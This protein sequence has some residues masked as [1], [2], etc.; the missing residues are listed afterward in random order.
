[1]G[2]RTSGI[3]NKQCFHNIY[4]KLI[5]M[6]CYCC[7]I[8]QD[9][10]STSTCILTT[11]DL[12]NT[13]R[14]ATLIQLKAV[15]ENPLVTLTQQEPRP[16]TFRNAINTTRSPSSTGDVCLA[17]DHS[18]ESSEHDDEETHV[19]DVRTT[20][21]LRIEGDICI[22]LRIVCESCLMLG[23]GG[24]VY[25]DILSEQAERPP[26][27]ARKNRNVSITDREFRSCNLDGGPGVSRKGAVS[28]LTNSH[29]AIFSGSFE[30]LQS[31]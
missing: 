23:E 19:F 28:H 20:C 25:I 29:P 30:R 13:A 1:M 6:T 5:L 16:A 22:A 9:S 21:K 4:C 15:I 8:L 7:D 10:P 31:K 2:I 18:D 11:L 27:P 17:S 26:L 14:Y 3:D 24:G 12:E